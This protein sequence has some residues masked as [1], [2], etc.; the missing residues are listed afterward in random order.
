MAYADAQNALDLQPHSFAAHK[1]CGI[2]V[3]ETSAF[4]GTKASIQRSFAVRDHF[5]RAAELNPRDPTSRHLLGLW[6][7]EV[8][9]IGW[10]TARIAATLFSTPPSSTYAEALTHLLAAESIEPGFYKKNQ[11]LIAKAKLKLGDREGAR[12]WL[13]ST[14]ALEV[15]SVDDEEAH[16]EAV[17]VL[18]SL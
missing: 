16:A 14:L 4:E 17:A 18:K 9:S 7:Y 2:L 13:T 8:A 6:H 15:T 11:L 3:S 12:S 1:W 5:I 10:A